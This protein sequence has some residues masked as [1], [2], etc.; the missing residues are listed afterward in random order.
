MISR[1]GR[2]SPSK[3]Q[4]NTTANTQVAEVPSAMGNFYSISLKYLLTRRQAAA[5]LAGILPFG[6]S[7]KP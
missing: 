2:L 5:L 4:S 6:Q 3:G 1:I 7:M